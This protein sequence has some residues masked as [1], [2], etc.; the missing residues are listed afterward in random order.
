VAKPFNVVLMQPPGYA[1]SHALAEA[2]EYAAS[3]LR[4]CGRPAQV[5]VNGLRHD[6]RNVVFC[7]HLMQ[8]A[9]LA[10]LPDDTILFNSEPL[11]RQDAWHHGSDVYR[12]ALA[13]FRVWDY[14]T[15]NLAAIP[16]ERKDFIPF[17]F[18]A[19]LRRPRPPRGAGKA[20][21]FYG[22][23]TP[24][25]RSLLAKL[26]DA[27]IEVTYMHNGFGAQRD[28]H[29]WDAWAVLNLHKTEDHAVFEP[30]RCFY[31]LINR[32]PVIGEESSDDAAEAFRDAMH[33]FPPEELALRVRALQDD[34][35]AFAAANDRYFAAFER[36]SAAAQFHEAIMR[37][38]G[39]GA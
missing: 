20:L 10:Q 31:P 15:R 35:P 14:S 33:F 3:M 27:D 8:R 23:P 11:S 24:W 6:A 22:V 34:A 25:R 37:A 38:E 32:V 30:I 4:A 28:A 12:D 2:A 26:A 36:K 21:L 18:C 5:A 7:P 17:W 1:F 16:H 9:D 39:S 19:E 13:R 29:L